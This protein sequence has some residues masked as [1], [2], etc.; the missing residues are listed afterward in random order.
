MV[1]KWNWCHAEIHIRFQGKNETFVLVKCKHIQLFK[2]GEVRDNPIVLLSSSNSPAG[3][4]CLHPCSEHCGKLDSLQFCWKKLPI[5]FFS[6]AESLSVHPHHSGRALSRQRRSWWGGRLPEVFS[7][8]RK[9]HTHLETCV[10]WK[11][12]SLWVIWRDED[13]RKTDGFCLLCSSYSIFLTVNSW[14]Y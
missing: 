2:D 7:K 13:P 12:P 11:A 4:T 14:S 6:P 10:F 3:G 9:I 1:W 8:T 5:T